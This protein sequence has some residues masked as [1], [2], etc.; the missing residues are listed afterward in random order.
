[1]SDLARGEGHRKLISSTA[2]ECHLWCGKRN[3]VIDL[4][5]FFDDYQTSQPPAAGTYVHWW[6][7]SKT[8]LAWP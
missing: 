5:A 3:P 6:L 1:M 7:V 8:M 2:A 4:P